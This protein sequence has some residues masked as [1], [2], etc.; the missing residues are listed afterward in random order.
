MEDK[1]KIKQRDLDMVQEAID[2]V[3]EGETIPI[4]RKLRKMLRKEKKKNITDD[5]LTDTYE[6]GHY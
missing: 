3:Y 6:G 2:H 1:L 5:L 4:S